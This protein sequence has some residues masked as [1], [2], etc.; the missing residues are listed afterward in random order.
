MNAIAENTFS[1]CLLLESIY[2]IW[3]TCAY[4]YIYTYIWEL[5]TFQHL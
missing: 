4:I 3:N 5:I 2:K 1:L